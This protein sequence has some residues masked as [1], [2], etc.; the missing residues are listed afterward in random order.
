[1]TSGLYRVRE[2]SN[3]VRT[4]GSTSRFSPPARN[5]SAGT[6]AG[7]C[8][9]ARRLSATMEGPRMGIVTT[10]ST[11]EAPSRYLPP[12]VG[13]EPRNFA[14]GYCSRLGRFPRGGPGGILVEEDAGKSRRKAHGQ[15]VANPRGVGG[16]DRWGRADIDRRGRAGGAA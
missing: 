2:P 4:T 11:T 12:K 16:M 9:P 6:V 13:K 1:M 3:T 5:G 7:R 15:S 10:P 14:N 8:C